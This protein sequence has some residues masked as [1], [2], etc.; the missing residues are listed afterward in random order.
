MSVL[1]AKL[2]DPDFVHRGPLPLEGGSVVIRNNDVSTFLI[3][4]D[5]SSDQWASMV[6]QYGDMKS[7]HVQLFDS[8]DGD[9]PLMSGIIT[10]DTVGRAEYPTAQWSGRCHL[11]YLDGMITLPSPSRAA[12]NQT[13]GS[14]YKANGSASTVIHNLVRSHR[15]DRS[16]TRPE[17]RTPLQVD[18]TVPS[19]GGNVRVETRFKP[20]LEEVQQLAKTGDTIFATTMDNDGTIRFTQ[21]V[22]T[23]RSRYIRLAE[24]NDALGEWSMERTRPE[25]TKVLV[26]GQGEGDARTLILVEGN[27]NEW[28]VNRLVFQDRRDTDELAD[29]QQAGEDTLLDNAETATISLDLVDTPDMEFGKDY[30]LGDIVTVQL[31]DG[32]TIVDGV[33][34]VE[35][36]YTAQGRT[37]KLTVGPTGEE[38]EPDALVKLVKDL[39][40]RLQ[41][42]ETR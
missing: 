33:Q 31:A 26:A 24:D 34:E 8:L 32:A 7:W 25:V 4:I 3:D 21:S 5:T 23:D 41:A 15:A 10:S 12:D 17:F 28:G 29:L 11:D 40:A 38:H 6:S 20:L 9:V 2:Y 1:T 13:D 37:G 35:L 22:P 19:F 14:H 18:S 30:W 27:E 39:R 16:P 36:D 42:L